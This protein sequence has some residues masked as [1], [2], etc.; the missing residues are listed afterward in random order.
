MGVYKKKRKKKKGVA[1]N[2]PW[3][4]HPLSQRDRWCHMIDAVLPIRWACPGM[5]APPPTGPP[6]TGQSDS[7]PEENTDRT[8][9]R[10]ANYRAI[11]PPSRNRGRRSGCSTSHKAYSHKTDRK[12]FIPSYKSSTWYH[13]WLR[14]YFR[15][16]MEKFNRFNLCLI[17]RTA[18]GAETRRCWACQSVLLL[19]SWC[20]RGNFWKN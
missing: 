17:Y 7:H 20:A 4:N 1:L 9:W 15:M 10:G 6:Q 5:P 18:L 13:S 3:T 2:P 12:R 19:L 8:F 14:L 16:L 11:L